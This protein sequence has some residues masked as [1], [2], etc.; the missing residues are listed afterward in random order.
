M[1]LVGREGQESAST[2]AKPH[3]TPSE[4]ESLGEPSAKPAAR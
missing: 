1:A 3:C 4:L 2:K